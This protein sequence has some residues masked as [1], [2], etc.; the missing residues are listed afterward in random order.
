MSV[1]SL[2]IKESFYLFCDGAFIHI[3][4]KHLILQSGNKNLGGPSRSKA[5]ASEVFYIVMSSSH[6]CQLCSAGLLRTMDPYVICHIGGPLRIA[7]CM[8]LDPKAMTPFS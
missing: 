4:S 1:K 7:I 6:M 5:H 3:N 2:S 8:L